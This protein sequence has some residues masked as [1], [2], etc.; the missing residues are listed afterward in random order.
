MS[1][2]AAARVRRRAASHCGIKPSGD[3]DL[4]LV[5][6]TDGEPVAGRRRVH[7]EQ[8]DRRAGRHDQRPPRR[9][10]GGRAAAVILNSGN[11]NA[12][13][14]QPG[15]G[16]RP[17]DDR[18]RGRRA[19]LRAGRGARLLHRPHRLS[20]CPID[21]DRRGHRPLVAGR[22]RTAD[23]GVAAAEAIRTTDTHRKE[24][25]VHGAGLR[26]S[27]AWPRARRCSPRTWRRCSPC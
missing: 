26:A 23:G 25:V 4:T 8:D 1:V 19:R 3:P 21:A 20:R 2:T 9:S 16:R 14:G 13:T 17:A 11:A 18:A 15:R 7:A 6:T 5:A 27:G 22:R 12:A 24:A 10:R